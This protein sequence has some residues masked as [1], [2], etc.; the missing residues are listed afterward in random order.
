MLIAQEGVAIAPGNHAF[1][2]LQRELNAEYM[3]QNDFETLRRIETEMVAP[4]SMEALDNHL[5]VVKQIGARSGSDDRRIAVLSDDLS[6]KLAGLRTRFQA[7]H[8]TWAE[9]Q[10]PAKG[11]VVDLPPVPPP[12]ALPVASDPDE[13]LQTTSSVARGKPKWMWW[14]AVVSALVVLLVIG[15]T[16]WWL[17]HRKTSP[18]Q[19]EL[20]VEVS[21]DGAE[22]TID[23]AAAG[24]APVKKMLPAG[25]HRVEARQSGF[26]D[27]AKTVTVGRQSSGKVAL[28]MEVD[29]IPVH[30]VTDYRGMAIKLDGK[31]FVD[32]LQKGIVNS[33]LS[34]DD[35]A[36]IFESASGNITARFGLNLK[37]GQLEVKGPAT[38][39][40]TK[41]A[42]LV[43]SAAGASQWLLPGDAEVFVD[44]ASISKKP[45]TP[46]PVGGHQVKLGSWEAPFETGSRVE[47]F[48]FMTSGKLYGNLA[49]QTNVQEAEIYLNGEKNHLRAPATIPSVP[50][51]NVRLRVV[52][53]GYESYEATIAIIANAVTPVNAPLKKLP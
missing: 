5:A 15:G 50:V 52:K 38:V 35:G 27:T 7:G 14:P 34:A 51:R 43:T 39:N 28:A 8:G 41:V 9:A 40:L 44:G 32:E 11:E 16:L 23:G 4:P 25:E 1:A 48:V 29:G 13:T 6:Q 42:V 30:F 21:P 45:D 19:F 12:F 36:H 47:A 17:S 22:V 2:Q 10:A 49:I 26:K 46:L 20:A 24:R 33:I 18:K 53:T 3:R 31:P 37:G